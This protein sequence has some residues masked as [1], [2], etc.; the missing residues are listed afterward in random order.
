MY[1]RRLGTLRRNQQQ[2]QPGDWRIQLSS[3][4]MPSSTAVDAAARRLLSAGAD[5]ARLSQAQDGLRVEMAALREG[6]V[7]RDAAAVQH[8]QLT[9]EERDG[10]F[11]RLWELLREGQRA[12][13]DEQETFRSWAQEAG[14]R[15]KEMEGYLLSERASAEAAATPQD[16]GADER[17]TN[18]SPRQQQQQQQQQRKGMVDPSGSCPRG[19][20]KQSRPEPGAEQRGGRG[21]IS[22]STGSL[23]SGLW[24]RRMGNRSIGSCDE[25][26]ASRAVATVSARGNGG[27]GTTP[28]GGGGSQRGEKGEHVRRLNRAADAAAATADAAARGGGYEQRAVASSSVGAETTTATAKRRAS[29]RAMRL[30]RLPRLV[31]GVQAADQFELAKERL[32]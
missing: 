14:S 2:R 6:L 23:R 28:R 25:V 32:R 13:R 19:A 16:M 1:A 22:G 21:G 29:A 15:M 9:E 5:V 4:A 30:D 17:R 18:S 24:A 8:Q 20:I 31:G 27:G 10:A 26:D 11:R 7:A 12:L 3:A